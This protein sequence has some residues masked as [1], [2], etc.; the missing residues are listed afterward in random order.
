MIAWKSPYYINKYPCTD[1]G[2]VIPFKVYDI[3]DNGGD[4]DI[5][6]KS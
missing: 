6:P 2:E 3:T 5:I 4:F 1:R